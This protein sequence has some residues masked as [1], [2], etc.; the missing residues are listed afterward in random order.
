[1]VGVFSLLFQIWSPLDSA[2]PTQPS[3]KTES[4][5]VTYTELLGSDCLQVVE[6]NNKNSVPTHIFQTFMEE[7]YLLLESFCFTSPLKVSK[8]HSGLQGVIQRGLRLQKWPYLESSHLSYA[9]FLSEN[10]YM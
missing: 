8:T 5:D 3:E 6:F 4:D 7:F 9:I 1:L 2:L 10:T